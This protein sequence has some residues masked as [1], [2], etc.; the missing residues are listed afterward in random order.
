VRLSFCFL[1]L[2]LTLATA[3]PAQEEAPRTPINHS[4]IAFTLPEKDLLPESVAYDPLEQTFYVGSTRKGKIVKVD[5]QGKVTDFIAPRQDGLWMVIGMKVDAA[6]RAL[7]VNSSYGDN[8]IGYQKSNGSPAGVFKF[9]LRSGKLIRKYVLDKPGETHFFNDLVINRRGDVFITHMFKEPALHRIAAGRDE[10]ELLARPENFSEPNGIALSEDE[11]VLFVAT[12]EGISALDVAHLARHQL[13]APPEVSLKG[14]DGLYFY[15]RSLIAIHPGRKLVRRYFLDDAM[16]SVT[17]AETIEAHHPMFN[18]PTTGVV[19]KD[20]FYYVA[21]AQFGSFN[22]DGSLFPPERLYEPVILK[23]ALSE[24]PQR[25]SRTLNRPDLK[26]ETV[27]TGLEIPWSIG[28]TPGGRI[29]VTERR[30]RIRVIENG[31]LRA[32]PWATLAVVQAGDAGLRGLAIAPDFAKTGHVF[33]AATVR[34]QNGKLISRIYRF[35]ERNKRGVDPV[36]IVDDIPC[37]GVHAGGA[38]AFGPDGMLYLSVG[39]VRVLDAVQDVKSTV[40]KILRY[41]PDGSV[42][43]D[44]PFAGS[45]VYALGVRNPQGMAWHTAAGALFATEHGP[46]NFPGEGGRLDQDELNLILPRGNYGWP[47]VSGMDSDERFIKPLAEWTPAIAPAGLA[48]CNVKESVWYGHLFVAG[49]RGQQ[50]RRIR[51]EKAPGAGWR[52]VEEEPLFHQQFGR[53]RAVAMGPDGYL[54][55]ATSNRDSEGQEAKLAAALDDRL[56]RLRLAG[57]R[58]ASGSA[59]QR[60]AGSPTFEPY[61]DLGERHAGRQQS[62]LSR[63]RQFR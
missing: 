17:R 45:P 4:L 62:Q 34:A 22:K 49:M 13:T 24:E 32:A 31:R 19:V 8:L 41:R 51:V 33:V 11:R 47:V 9:D 60:T 1:A 43:K 5:K 38:L 55:F 61:D 3:S 6:R 35:T 36:V 54:Y 42:P 30:G 20:T 7:W 44:N 53:I 23:V 37:P 27:A 56:F 18:V 48:V 10:L 28:F 59:A 50:L 21:N 16:K 46:T 14:I 40:G 2:T 39:D 52:V 15:K 26:L 57:G 25:G 63:A 12:D 58:Q 29:F